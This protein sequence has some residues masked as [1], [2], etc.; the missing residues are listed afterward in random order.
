MCSLQGYDIMLPHLMGEL[1]VKMNSTVN[2]PDRFE[3]PVDYESSFMKQ[4]DQAVLATTEGILDHWWQYNNGQVDIALASVTTLTV[5]THFDAWLRWLGELTTAGQINLPRM[6]M[7]WG[8]V[9]GLAASLEPVNSDC[10]QTGN[11]PHFASIE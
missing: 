8:T 4:E 7:P 5:Q 1:A 9:P 6:S 10:Q 3:L 2:I 11:P